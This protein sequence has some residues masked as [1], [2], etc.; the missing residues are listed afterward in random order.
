MIVVLHGDE[1]FTRTRALAEL[2][3]QVLTD[4]GL[5][6][7]N[8]ILLEGGVDVA[9][10][11][12]EADAIPFLGDARLVIACGWLTHV[13]EEAKRGR[14]QERVEALRAYLPHVPETTYLVF[15]EPRPLGPTHPLWDL[16]QEL[17]EKGQ[18]QVRAF[19]LPRNARERRQFV[20]KWVQE[21]ARRLDMVLDPAAERLLISLLEPNLRLLHQELE[22]L[23]TFVGPGGYVTEETVQALVPYT[24]EANIFHMLNAIRDRNT[25]R[26]VLLLQ[27]VLRG[28]QHPLQVLSLIARQ[29]RIYMGVKELLEE[30]KGDDEI[31]AA[32]RIP[33]W[34]L[35]REKSFARRVSWSY[36]ERVMERLLQVDARI[37]QGEIAPDLALYTLV[38]E[39]SQGR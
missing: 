32:L 7:L 38:L 37:K 6:D 23:R 19:T 3:S 30:Q 17:V 8:L 29:Y 15:D 25:R 24:Q 26:A 12:E 10:L 2:R 9:R 16:L 34:T 28:G 39:L 13:A 31:V 14:G 33:A 21:E 35:S 4:P 36:L 22:K 18:A 5:G 20:T 27:Q 11:R 1:E